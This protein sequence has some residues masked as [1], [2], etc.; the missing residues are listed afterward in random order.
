MINAS[1][2][3]YSATLWAPLVRQLINP[4]ANAMNSIELCAGLVD[5]SFLGNTWVAVHTASNYEHKINCPA[6][7]RECAA[8]V[9]AGIRMDSQAQRSLCLGCYTE[10]GQSASWVGPQS[11]ALGGISDWTGPG[12]RMSG[13]HASGLR[14]SNGKHSVE[15]GNAQSNDTAVMTLRTS[16]SGFSWPLRIVV[17]EARGQFVL[18]PANTNAL[19]SVRIQMTKTGAV[20]LGTVLLGGQPVKMGVSP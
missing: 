1:D 17:D 15:L 8:A 14:V 10:G 3:C 18:Q 16:S 20:P 13:L 5:H 2:N 7:S 12:L 19:S 6:N 4:E 9:Y 11:I